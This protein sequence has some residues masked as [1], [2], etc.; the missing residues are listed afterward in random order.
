MWHRFGTARHPCEAASTSFSLLLGLGGPPHKSMQWPANELNEEL[1]LNRASRGP[2][3]H[4]AGAE[5]LESS[6]QN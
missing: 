5:E 3:A 4:W 2:L 1:H 6:Y